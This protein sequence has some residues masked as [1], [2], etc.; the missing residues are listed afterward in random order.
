MLLIG[1]SYRVTIM[2]KRMYSLKVVSVYLVSALL[3][4]WIFNVLF[5][6]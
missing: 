2:K 1:I 4:V 3:S 5:M 6:V